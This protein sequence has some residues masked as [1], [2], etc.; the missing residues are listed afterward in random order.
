MDMEAI[1]KI[2]RIDASARRSSSTTRMLTDELIDHL[3]D[4]GP[5]QLQTRDLASGLPLLDED[6]INANFTEAAARTPDQQ[7]KLQLSDELIA[8]LKVADL[9]VIGSPIYN[10]SVPSVLKAWIDMIARA[11]LTFRY[12]ENGVEGLLKGKKAYVIVPSGGVPIGSP[13]DFATPYLRHA[14]GFVGI[15]DV[16]FVAATGADRDNGEALDNAR[17]QIAELVHLAPQAA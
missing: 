13:M 15:T 17:A 10:F 2:L 1:T 3:S 6:W 9:L 7:R 16:E 8:E 12:T 4:Q 14:L 5:I 11:R